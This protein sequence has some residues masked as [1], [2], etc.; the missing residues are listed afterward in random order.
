MAFGVFLIAVAFIAAELEFIRNAASL[1]LVINLVLGRAEPSK[2]SLNL[3]VLMVRTYLLWC[4]YH[5]L[6][7]I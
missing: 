5:V 4:R 7:S 3:L 1:R 2:L 6:K